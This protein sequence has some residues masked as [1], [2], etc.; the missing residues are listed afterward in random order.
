MTVL[1]RALAGL[2]LIAHGL[3]H[4]LYL[5][6]DVEEFTLDDSWIVGANARRPVAYVLMTATVVAFALVGLAV[7]GVPLLSA[8]WPAL[9]IAASVVSLVLLVLYWHP[10]LVFGVAIDLALIVLAVLRPDWTQ[11]IA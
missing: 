6:P 8:I 7:W 10:R 5:A 3:V 9:M 4:L 1:I 11:S 2:L